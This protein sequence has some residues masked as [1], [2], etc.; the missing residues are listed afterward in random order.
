MTTAVDAAT[1]DALASLAAAAGRSVIYSRGASSVVLTAVP[2]DRQ[3][4]IIDAD[5]IP[6]TVAT[7]DYDINP[8]DLIL[9]GSETRPQRGDQIAESLEGTTITYEVLPDGLLPP[10]E[11]ADT[12]GHQ[13]LR[14]HTKRVS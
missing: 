10:Y 4:E 9:D 6:T 3:R 1:A 8:D 5:G 11:W 2:G 12:H 14:A 13:W 7:R